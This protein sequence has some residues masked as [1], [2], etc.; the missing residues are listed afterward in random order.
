MSS[1]KIYF[2]KLV[3]F[4]AFLAIA[5]CKNNREHLPAF[6]G[7]FTTN[8]ADTI[9]TIAYTDSFLK[10]RKTIPDSCYKQFTFPENFLGIGA[11]NAKIEVKAIEKIN[12]GTSTGYIL[13][14]DYP[15][16]KAVPFFICMYVYS[17][18]TKKLSLPITL[19]WLFGSEGS[20]NETQSWLFD[21][22]KDS[23][24][25]IVSSTYRCYLLAQD[26]IPSSFDT[27]VVNVWSDSVFKPTQVLNYAAFKNS[28]PK[29]SGDCF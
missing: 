26:A 19:C 24:R 9:K 27:I 4:A 1:I 16:Q 13:S 20:E 10:S 22:D 25:D 28:F 21:F 7:F 17:P 23:N 15:G 6:D 11:D 12:I 14:F 5:G 2:A 29:K 3:S 18:A 8:T